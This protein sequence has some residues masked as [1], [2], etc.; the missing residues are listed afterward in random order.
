MSFRPWPKLCFCRFLFFGHGRNTVFI[1]F[2]LSATA[3]TLFLL[4]F[5]SSA[6]A[7]SHFS[8]FSRFRPRPKSD[9]STEH[10]KILTK[11]SRLFPQIHGW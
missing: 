1:I 3:E 5:Y 2:Q 11:K 8:P 6:L 7:E 4:F 9:N 10:Y